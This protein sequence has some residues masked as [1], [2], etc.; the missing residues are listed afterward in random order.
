MLLREV[1]VLANSY[2]SARDFLRDRHI[3]SSVAPHCST[4]N[5]E[6]TEIKQKKDT[7]TNVQSEKGVTSRNAK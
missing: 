7:G 1:M 6:M 5:R 2:E 4:C 3:I